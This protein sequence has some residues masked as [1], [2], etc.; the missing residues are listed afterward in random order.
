[1]SPAKLLGLPQTVDSIIVRTHDTRWLSVRP[2]VAVQDRFVTA[3]NGG[4]GTR[5]VLRNLIALRRRED[6]E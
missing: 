4:G 1:M 3:G 6:K 5:K 2:Q